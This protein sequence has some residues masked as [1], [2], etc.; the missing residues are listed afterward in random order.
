MKLTF[1]TVIVAAM[2]LAAAAACSKE[3]SAPG[4]EEGKEPEVVPADCS[5][6]VYSQ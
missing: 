5:P 1:K 3:T 2:A 4:K 6:E